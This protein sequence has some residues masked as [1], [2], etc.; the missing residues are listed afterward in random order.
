MCAMFLHTS[1][2]F[3][4][5]HFNILF[6]MAYKK[7]PKK[8]DALSI[9]RAVE[10]LCFQIDWGLK[11]LGAE[12]GDLFHQLAKVEVDFISELNLTQD[13]LAIKSL[14]DGVKQNLQI[15]PTPESGDFTHSIVALAL[16]I[17]SI[18]HLNNISLPESWRDQIE[19]KLLTIYY[20]EKL[21]NKI[22][23]WAK[24]NGYS[25]SNYLGRPIVKFNQLYL[26]IE[27]TR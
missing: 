9:K 8:K 18:S 19:K 25:T 5:T 13:I 26:I 7:N 1:P 2:L 14:V 3:L 11:L 27:R 21:R 12:K 17:A 20:P 10:S 16:G 22:V 24:A 6:V 4:H 15:E 23:D